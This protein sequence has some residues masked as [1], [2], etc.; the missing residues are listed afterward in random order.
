ME[1]L[2][3]IESVQSKADDKFSIVDGELVKAR[4]NLNS[5][6]LRELCCLISL[7]ISQFEP[8]FSFID[9]VIVGRRN[10]IAH[11]EDIMVPYE[12]LDELVDKS[13]ALMRLFRN[14]VEND[15]YQGR[16]QS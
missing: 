15:L 14:I 7:D 12:E 13:I 5:A 3:F 8:E 9:K 4:S 10:H 6:V 1:K 11:G 2:E 16:F